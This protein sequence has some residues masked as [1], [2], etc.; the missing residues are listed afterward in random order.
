VAYPD[1][2]EPMTRLGRE[3]R[4]LE[5]FY[6]EGDAIRHERV[7]RDGKPDW[8]LDVVA[9]PRGAVLFAL[10]LAYTPDPEE[11]VF[12]F[13]PPREAEFGFPL[14][15]YLRVP[16]E[17]FRVDADGVASVPYRLEGGRV[18]IRDRASRVAIYVAA[19]KVGERARIELLRRRLIERETALGFDPGKNPSDLAV[20]R[21]LLE[22][23]KN[24]NPN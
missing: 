6:L 2:L 10:D 22:T 14:P 20:L 5:D 3:I 12:Q 1:L 23:K 15:A 24:E 19:S 17:V 21:R 16:A 18:N 8:D 11:R 7:L 9:G 13:S 4:M